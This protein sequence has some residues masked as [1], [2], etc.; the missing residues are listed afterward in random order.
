MVYDTP[1][2]CFKL[3]LTL[4]HLALVEKLVK[5]RGKMTAQEH[6]LALN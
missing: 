2:L 5:I 4:L 3:M 1:E 6:H